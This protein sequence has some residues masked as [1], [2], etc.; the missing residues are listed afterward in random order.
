MSEDDDGVGGY[1]ERTRRHRDIASK[2]RARNLECDRSLA[3][4]S[5]AAAEPAADTIS[6]ISPSDAGL[7]DS[8][9]NA[10]S[11]DRAFARSPENVGRR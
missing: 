2:L 3:L 10:V 1:M 9:E 11:G 7:N 4:A 5:N 6:E 8:G